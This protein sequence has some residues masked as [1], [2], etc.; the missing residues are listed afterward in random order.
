MKEGH[1]IPLCLSMVYLWTVKVNGDILAS[2][3]PP[4]HL[5]GERVGWTVLVCVITD[6]GRGHL[7]VN[8]RSSEEVG[9]FSAPYSVAG[10]EHDSGRSAVAIVTVATS[11]WASYSCYV[12]HRHHPRAIRTHH[13]SFTG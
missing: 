13:A 12:R 7:E 9:P 1:R 10:D 8:W 3:A 6:L 2:L 11:V 4:L 5:A